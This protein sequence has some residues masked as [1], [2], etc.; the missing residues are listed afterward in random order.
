MSWKPVGSIPKLELSTRPAVLVTVKISI[1]LYINTG[2]K[3]QYGVHYSV[4]KLLNNTLSKICELS[5]LDCFKKQLK[6]HL[7]SCEYGFKFLFLKCY[8]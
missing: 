3:L 8:N 7:K 2:L 4:I 1:F 5:R 6:T